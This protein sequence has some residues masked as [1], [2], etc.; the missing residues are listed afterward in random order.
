MAK[1]PGVVQSTPPSTLYI[2]N[3]TGDG[4]VALTTVYPTT[5]PQDKATTDLVNHLRD[6]T[7]P[8]AVGT[9]A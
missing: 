4:Y 5:A 1:Q 8:Q 9:R 2:P 7:V 6:T 3:K